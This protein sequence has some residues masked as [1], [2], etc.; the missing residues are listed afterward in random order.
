MKDRARAFGESGGHALLARLQT[1][2]PRARFHLMGHSFGCIVAS[3]TVAGPAGAPDLPRPVDSLFLVQG[4]L[5]LW[6]YASDIPYAA[7]QLGCFR[8][9]VEHGL[10]RGP[11][12]TTRSSHD[13]AVGRFYPL[14]AQIR[15]QL[16]LG[17]DL[18]AYG[19]IGTFG[20]QGA[21]GAVD[22][23]MGGANF[24]YGFEAGTIYNLEASEIIKNGGGASG[25]H[26]DIAHPEVAH[27]FWSAALSRG[28]APASDAVA[29]SRAAARPGAGT[30]RAPRHRG[31]P[32]PRPLAAAS[33]SDLAVPRSTPRRPCAPPSRAARDAAAVVAAGR[34]AASSTSP[35]LPRATRHFAPIVGRPYASPGAPSA[36][37]LPIDLPSAQP[38]ARSSPDPPAATQRWVNVELEDQPR[39]RDPRRSRISGTRWLSTSTSP[40]A[41]RR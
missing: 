13:S 28:P 9:I 12:V 25:A 6:S 16:V 2:A 37:D 20:I 19:G 14:G 32:R 23:P 35:Q 41:P 30:G 5:S 33:G 3:A 39:R 4:A 11:I 8:R 22:M 24:A 17:D 26:S 1:A 10:V 27:A 40:N 7:R 36:R 29:G 18:P 31:G 38:T 15:K 34:A 21:K